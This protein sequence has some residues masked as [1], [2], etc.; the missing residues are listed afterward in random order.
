MENKLDGIK[1]NMFINIIQEYLEYLSECTF[2][3]FKNGGYLFIHNGETLRVKYG[4]NAI[5][6]TFLKNNESMKGIVFGN[7]DVKENSAL[8]KLF[9]KVMT[10]TAV[11]LAL[12]REWR[13]VNKKLGNNKKKNNEDDFLLNLFSEIIQKYIYRND[14]YIGNYFED[15]QTYILSLDGTTL[16]IRY[17]RNVEVLFITKS[18]LAKTITLDIMSRPSDKVAKLYEKILLLTDIVSEQKDTNTDK[19][20]DE[21][22]E[23]VNK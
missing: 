23:F 8:E 3:Y 10:L 22:I 18:G 7:D 2:H 19:F 4:E 6:I 13:K 15:S 12:N 11:S 17:K 9:D 1:I 14:E 16:K 5:R 21:V 20:I